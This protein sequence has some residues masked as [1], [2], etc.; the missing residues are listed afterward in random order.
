LGQGGS[1]EGIQGQ[2]RG[3][4]WTRCGEVLDGM[5]WDGVKRRV[6]YI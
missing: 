1:E 4:R 5:F 3:F 2:E 6:G